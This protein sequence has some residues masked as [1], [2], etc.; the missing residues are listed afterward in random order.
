MYK[1]KEVVEESKRINLLDLTKYIALMR[2][3][4]V[5][6]STILINWY[7]EGKQTGDIGL[8]LDLSVNE[9]TLKYCLN[10]VPYCYNIPLV[11][12][13]I[14]YGGYQY[15]M[16]CPDCGKKI[17]TLY[18]APSKTRFSCRKC[19]CLIYSSQ[20]HRNKTIERRFNKLFTKHLSNV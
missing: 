17:K 15:F 10:L 9:L 12:K 8:T 5:K 20:K 13:I 2:G 16:I 7:R 14:S 19:S 3:K 18:K 11:K 6:V 1:S 4:D